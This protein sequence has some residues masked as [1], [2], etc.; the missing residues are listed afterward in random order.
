MTGRYRRIWK[1]AAMEEF[2][3]QLKFAANI[4]DSFLWGGGFTRLP[5]R[6]QFRETQS[7][8]FD[9]NTSA[10]LAQQCGMLS[11]PDHVP[12]GTDSQSVSTGPAR[13]SSAVLQPE[14]EPD[15]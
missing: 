6:R 4:V 5:M 3:D 7:S 9:P 2:S 12:E 13:R 15:G 10:R 1:L 8:G 14:R 11:V